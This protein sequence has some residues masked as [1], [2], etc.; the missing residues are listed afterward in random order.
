VLKRGKE[1]TAKSSI[2]MTKNGGKDVM[3]WTFFRQKGVQANA[4]RAEIELGAVL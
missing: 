3:R 1:E 2:D 4:K